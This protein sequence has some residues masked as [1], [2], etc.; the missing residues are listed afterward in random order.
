MYE[1]PKE[2]CVGSEQPPTS[3]VQYRYRFGTAEFDE[4]SIELRVDGETVEIQRRPLEVLSVLLRHA[5][6]VV[7]RE[8]LRE[9]VWDNR[10]TVDN[11]LDT[12]L[13][14]LRHVLGARNAA[15][16]HTQPRVGFR[17]I[18]PVE[19]VVVGRRFSGELTLAAGQPVAH[20]ERISYCSAAWASHRTTR[21]GSHGTPRRR[22][23]GCTSSAPAAKDSR[24]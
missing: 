3:H 15:L 7:T 23:G 18:G 10:I 24:R 22:S 9:A 17:L 11:V 14:K 19:K 4:V 8:E 12:A 6:E 2:G 13:T 20:R 1:W 5:G 21:S 16:I